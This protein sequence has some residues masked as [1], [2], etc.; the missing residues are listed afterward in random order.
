MRGEQMHAFV[1]LA[2]LEVRQAQVEGGGVVSGGVIR[3]RTAR[4]SVLLK[5]GSEGWRYM[6]PGTILV[7]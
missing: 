6:E 1:D 2:P 3:L 5:Q 4:S 7:G